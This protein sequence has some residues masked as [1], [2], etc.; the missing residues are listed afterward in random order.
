MKIND[1][2][3]LARAVLATALSALAL[4][5]GCKDDSPCDEGQTEVLGA[6]YPAAA[7]GTS[8]MAGGAGTS[9]TAGTGGAPETDAGGDGGAPAEEASAEVGQPC[10]DTTGSS[11]CGGNAPICAPLPAG[12]ACTQVLCLDGEPNA[13]ACPAD[14]PCL[15]I[16]ANPSACLKF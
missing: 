8:G 9:S 2:H 15:A 13:G 6:C 12:P 1:K 14:W 11:D 5:A 3:G 7:A 4:A 16:G 10:T